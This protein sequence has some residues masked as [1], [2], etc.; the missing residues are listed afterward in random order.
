MKVAR[1]FA[2]PRCGAPAG[3]ECLTARTGRGGRPAASHLA[4][5]ALAAQANQPTPS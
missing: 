1:D 2:C 5:I 4:R 3:H